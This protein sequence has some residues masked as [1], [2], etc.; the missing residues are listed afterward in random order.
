M[1]ESNTVE[2]FPKLSARDME[3]A[4]I[5]FIE[6]LREREQ[7]W[8]TVRDDALMHFPRRRRRPSKNSDE[9]STG[10]VTPVTHVISTCP[11]LKPSPREDP[12]NGAIVR[13]AISSVCLPGDAFRYQRDEIS[14]VMIN[15]KN[16]VILFSSSNQ[17]SGL[18][19]VDSQSARRIYSITPNCPPTIPSGI[20][21][22]RFRFTSTKGFI[23]IGKIF[24]HNGI[25]DGVDAVT[26]RH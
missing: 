12:G 22:R 6:F 10:T 17:F 3:L 25:L 21:D 7:E 26:L 13:A 18:Y 5:G 16:F 23:E 20:V 11:S 14:N 2:Y 15:G 24:G 9:P 19:S 8:E 4:R 1:F